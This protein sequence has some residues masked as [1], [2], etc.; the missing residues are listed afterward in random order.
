[1]NDVQTDKIF[2]PPYLLTLAGHITL[3]FKEVW[4]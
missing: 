1:M 2:I 4:E 3:V